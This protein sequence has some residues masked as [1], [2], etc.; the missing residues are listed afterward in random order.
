MRTPTRHWTRH[1]LGTG[2]CGLPRAT[3]SCAANALNASL[4]QP[5]RVSPMAP[6]ALPLGFLLC[7]GPHFS[8]LPSRAHGF[9]VPP[10]LLLPQ[11]P[12]RAGRA[13][14]QTR[15]GEPSTLTVLSCHLPPR[16]LGSYQVLA[17]MYWGQVVWEPPVDFRGRF[18]LDQDPSLPIINMPSINGSCCC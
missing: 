16:P 8:S 4:T 11:E 17:S 3:S 14:A 6:E 1:A 15:Q 9:Q 5:S 2:R 18:I 10:R 12:H 13:G 7:Q